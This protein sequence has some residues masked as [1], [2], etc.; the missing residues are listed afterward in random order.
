MIPPLYKNATYEDVREDI[1][2]ALRSFPETRKGP[3]LA[4]DTGTGKTHTLYAIFAKSQEGDISKVAY[5]NVCQLFS[6]LRRN[7]SEKNDLKNIEIEELCLDADML[8]LDDIGA[9][10]TT[11]WTIE[12]LYLI[13]NSR[14]ENEK[15]TIFASNL[16]P[17]QLADRMG[18]RIASR[19]AA[20]TTLFNFGNKDR[21]V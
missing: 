4:G 10:K 1:K 20:M 3:Y 13:I 12:K 7:V 8:L 2:Q 6:I 16:S 5:F 11:D 21:R 17:D 9:E 18:D 14:Y 15:C 19:I